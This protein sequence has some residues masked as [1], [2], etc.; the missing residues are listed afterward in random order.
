LN[1]TEQPN[2]GPRLLHELVEAQ[3]RRTP[4]AT[5]V[6]YE[7]ERLTYAQLDQRA[8]RLARYLV[9]RGGGPERLVAVAMPRGL[10]LPV[11]MLGVLKAGGAY[12]P[13][14]PVYPA[15]RRELILRDSG[16]AVVLTE[17]PPGL[18][19]L[20]ADPLDE[21]AVPVRPEHPA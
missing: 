21:L 15:Q 2:R 14:D 11:A 20:P 17:L 1:A 7:G 8:N 9:A 5:A 19:G 3:A 13:V 10:D 6:V 4:D 18:D 16:A 12:L